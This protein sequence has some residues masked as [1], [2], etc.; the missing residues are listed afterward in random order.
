MEIVMFASITL[1]VAV[2]ELLDALD[3]EL[4]E[5]DDAEYD[6]DEDGVI[7]FYDDETD[8]MYYYDEDLDDW[9]EVGEDGTVWYFDELE[10]VYFYDDES[11]EWILFTDEVEC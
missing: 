11:D 7:W 3:I 10:N 2:E 1:L 9:A 5:E 6:I 4:I 8:S